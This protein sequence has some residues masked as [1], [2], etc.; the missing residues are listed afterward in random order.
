MTIRAKKSRASRGSFQSSKSLSAAA[1]IIRNG[2][3]FLV[4]THRNPDGDALGSAL[5]LAAG[6]RKLGK[7]AKVYDADPVPGTLRFLPGSSKVSRILGNKETYDATFVVDCSNLSRVGEAFLFHPGKGPTVILDH[8]ARGAHNGDLRVVD[9][10]A[11]SSGVV[12]H[13]LLR[14]LG[15]EIDRA[16][17]TSLYV[18]L[19][20]DTGNFRYA[21]TDAGVLTLAS[22]L[23]RAGA[24]PDAVSRALNDTASRGRLDLLKRALGTLELFD[25]GRIG[26]V[27]VTRA[28]LRRSG[29]RIEMA[30]DFVDYPRSLA[31]VE[32][33]V[34]FRESGE[35]WRVSLRSKTYADVGSAAVY[36][37]GGGHRRA[38]GFTLPGTF[39]SVKRCTLA[40]LRRELSKYP[41]YK[42]K[43]AC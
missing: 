1:R 43:T 8:H 13:R 16:I 30:D 42:R 2:R 35:G 25:G 20:T 32:I 28:M 11:A 19:V 9:P 39:P 26:C 7:T 3:R 36:L 5:A 14:R 41:V 10:N 12:V 24:D 33:A 15:L 40:V 27:T 22:G 18:T 4:A 29:A 38:A 23:V 31:S 37:G 21:N 34:L 6:L 17:A